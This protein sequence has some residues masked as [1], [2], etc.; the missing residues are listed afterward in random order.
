MSANQYSRERFPC[1]VAHDPRAPKVAAF[2]NLLAVVLSVAAFINSWQNVWGT[3]GFGLEEIVLLVSAVGLLGLA[4]WG[5]TE[6]E[7]PEFSSS[8]SSKASMF[9]DFD[10]FQTP[11]ASNHMSYESTIPSSTTNSNQTSA[12]ILTSILGEQQQTSETQV[13]SAITTLSLGEFGE[14]AHQE[15]HPTEFT[16]QNN[17]LR[18]AAPTSEATGAALN[19]VVIQ[20]VPLPGKEG[21]PTVDPT[22][23]PGLEPDRVFVTEGVAEIPLPELPSIEESI[24]NIPASSP[25]IQSQKIPVELPDLPDEASFNVPKVVPKLDLPELD[26]L[27]TD[28][29]ETPNTPSISTPDLPDLDDLF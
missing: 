7:I 19:R 18:E 21:E 15:A 22:T 11:I 27:F 29:P 25:S 23:I 8:Y 5:N 6:H 1:H 24:T 26:D 4:K 10:E 13:K 3:S 9:E 17:H 20:P 14:R 16:K 28:L 12:T 2:S